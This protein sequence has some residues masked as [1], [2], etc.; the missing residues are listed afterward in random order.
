VPSSQYSASKASSDLI[1]LANAHTFNQPIVVTRCTNNYGPYQDSEKLI[2]TIICR[3]INNQQIPIY[4]TGLN[5]RDW[6]FVD[7]HVQALTSILFNA[8]SGQIINISGDN[9]M[10]NLAVA[11]QI[12]EILGKPAS[13]IEYVEDRKGHDLRYSLDSSKLQNELSWKPQV[14]FK[15]GLAQTID[16]Y[17]SRPDL[18]KAIL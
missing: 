3:A 14:D 18:R 5:V 16:W 10:S 13:L 4:G 11:N 2:P 7:D 12:L 17:N 8:D 9:E 6:L 15:Q 1:V